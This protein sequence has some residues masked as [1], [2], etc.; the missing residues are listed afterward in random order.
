MTFSRTSISL[1][2][3]VPPYM[4]SNAVQLILI[5][6]I[7]HGKKAFK[8]CTRK[9][10]QTTVRRIRSA[11]PE[12]PH[13]CGDVGADLLSDPRRL[14]SVPPGTDALEQFGETVIPLTESERGIPSIWSNTDA[15]QQ[16]DPLLRSALC[17]IQTLGR[18]G[19]GIPPRVHPAA[20]LVCR[21]GGSDHAA[22]ETAGRLGG[23]PDFC[24]APCVHGSS[25]NDFGTG[26]HSLRLLLSG[27][28]RSISISTKSAAKHSMGGRLRCFSWRC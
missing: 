6:G 28:R 15:S 3:A 20:H 19:A 17:A 24:P 21:P 26:N 12:P 1:V 11:P 7:D 2:P 10:K 5:P 13:R 8:D 27:G 18:V 22:T 16:Y 9:Q 23:R 25:G 4:Y 14:L